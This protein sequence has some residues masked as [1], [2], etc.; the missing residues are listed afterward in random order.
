MNSAHK[1]LWPL[2]GLLLFTG[3]VV[4]TEIRPVVHEA[5]LFWQIRAGEE[6][7]SGQGIQTAD[8]WSHTVKGTPWYNFQ[9]LATVLWATLAHAGTAALP[10]ARLAL[11]GLVTF[12]TGALCALHGRNQKE[13]FSL[14]LGL[15]PLVIAGATIRF[16]LRPEVLIIPLS[17]L[18]FW[19]WLRVAELSRLWWFLTLT[20]LVTWAQVHTVVLPFAL[21][22]TG[23]LAAPGLLRPS[24]RWATVAGCLTLTLLPLTTP[25]GLHIV[26]VLRDGVIASAPASMP[27]IDAQGIAY[28][29]E[30]GATFGGW[31]VNSF[32][33]VVF[34]C[35][36]A[37][38]VQISR[39]IR[40]PG[41]VERSRNILSFVVLLVFLI[42][43]IYKVRVSL[44]ADLWACF[45]IVRWIFQKGLPANKIVTNTAILVTSTLSLLYW[46]TTT[47]LST[48]STLEHV[49]QEPIDTRKFSSETAEFL[50]K[51]HP[52]VQLYNDYSLGGYL[53]WKAPTYP[54]FW[55]GRF[56]PFVNIGRRLDAENARLP[57]TS[58]IET[59]NINTLVFSNMENDIGTEIYPF[60]RD[61]YPSS[62]FALVHFDSSSSIMVRRSPENYDYIS[63]H[64]IFVLHAGI[65][66]TWDRL[67]ESFLISPFEKQVARME[68]T[69]K[70]ARAQSG[71]VP[72]SLV[73]MLQDQCVQ[74][75]DFSRC[76][77]LLLHLGRYYQRALGTAL[78]LDGLCSRSQNPLLCLARD[79]LQLNNTSNIST[80]EAACTHH[81]LACRILGNQLQTEDK[82]SAATAAW[83]KACAGGDRH[84]CVLASLEDPQA[85]D[86]AALCAQGTHL[87]CSLQ[88][89]LL[90]ANRL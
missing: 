43:S 44:Y 65:H 54:V 53:I 15:F 19:I 2:G 68:M 13:R 55:D 56:I 22:M 38:I 32:A 27:I 86:L 83:H 7:L 24:Q 71:E 47:R 10:I 39:V 67:M 33:S 12:V 60:Y 42:A 11:I 28:F 16:E 64:E 74:S 6:I 52:P 9:W 80:L 87:A 75:T 73:Q 31:L 58:V 63:Q 84:A 46:T 4:L 72:E 37:G 77:V 81:P 51:T 57:T 82:S 59:Y 45:L 61:L 23:A 70:D 26:T 40:E 17:I 21:L 25:L 36:L 34:L 35:V 30:N 62:H 50:E 29:M 76:G 20:T 78:P 41:L 49:I 66:L 90:K 3:L 89:G 48:R 14:L 8:S 69:Q 79:L 5:D 1:F 88:F 85:A 18:L